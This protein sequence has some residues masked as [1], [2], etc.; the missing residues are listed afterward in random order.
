MS[1]IIIAL[2]VLTT[3]LALVILKLGAKNGA[4][5]DIVNGKLSFNLTIYTITGILLYS[6]SFILYTYLL[7]RYDLGYI[8]PLAAA[9]VYILIFGASYFV[10]NESF[11]P[12]KVGGILLIVLGLILLNMDK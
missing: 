5:A 7:S 3:S 12:L 6:V 2:Y 4:P 1:K 9:F 8:I 11:T 10:F